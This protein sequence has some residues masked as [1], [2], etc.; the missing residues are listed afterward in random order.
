MFRLTKKL[1]TLNPPLRSLSK[2]KLGDLPKKTREAYKSLCEKQKE[3]LE[4]PTREAT[5]EETKALK[6]WQLLADL[7]EEFYKQRS[8]LNW[9]EVGDGNN[10]VF[11]NAAKIRE[12]I[13]SI[14]EIVCSDGSIVSNEEDI[15]SESVRFFADFLSHKPLDFEGVSEEI[16]QGLLQFRCSE[17]DQEDLQR[18]V[19]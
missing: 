9:L 4:N 7:E 6:W 1:K 10:K 5:K 11:H 19:T 3:T 15:K 17:T 16:L 2:E 14:R 12:I 8:K 13:N 18:E